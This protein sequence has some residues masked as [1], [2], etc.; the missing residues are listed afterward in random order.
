[1]PPITQDLLKALDLADE[2]A[3]VEAVGHA[4]ARAFMEGTAVG[5]TEVAAQAASQGVTLNIDWLGGPAD[6]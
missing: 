2:P 5:V 3:S 1:L 4:L 6:N